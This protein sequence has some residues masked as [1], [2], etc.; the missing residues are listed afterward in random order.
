MKGKLLDKKYKESQDKFNFY[1][2]FTKSSK[3]NQL[4]I[5]DELI[6]IGNQNTYKVITN[7]KII[8]INKMLSP[9]GK[10]EIAFIDKKNII[11][12]YD[13]GMPE[14]LPNYI[15]NNILYFDIEKTKIGIQ[16]FGGLAPMFCIPKINCYD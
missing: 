14:N 3:I 16:I 4:Q 11:I 8:G 7:F 2:K 12:V 6:D 9:R 15:E 1:K 5:I 10:S 13:M